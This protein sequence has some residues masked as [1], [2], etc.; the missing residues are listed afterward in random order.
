MGSNVYIGN[1]R[2]KSFKKLISQTICNLGEISLGRVVSNLLK[3]AQITI[4]GLML[5]AKVGVE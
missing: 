5:G 4:F 3:F 1:Y 2:R